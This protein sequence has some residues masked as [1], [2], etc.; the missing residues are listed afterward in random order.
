[1]PVGAFGG[2]REIM[3]MISPSG[4]VYQ[5]G[6]LSGN[7]MA[8]AAGYSALG[9]IRA[10]P[11]IYTQLEEKSAYLENGFR[12]NMKALGKNFAMN[13]VGSMTTLF[14]TEEKVTDFKSAI[15]SDTVLYGKYFHEML[16]R[17]IYLAPAQFE[18]AFVSMA[19]TTEDLDRTINAH[20][21]AIKTIAGK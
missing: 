10:H 8:M 9:Y 6:T 15:K 2:K 11:E 18:A 17:G 14:F 5:A 20:Y 16:N 13:R 3:E 4:P 7:P 12:E 1:M 19:H 21:D